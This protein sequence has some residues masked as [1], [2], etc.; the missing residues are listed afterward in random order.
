MSRSFITVFMAFAL[1]GATACSDD[2][3][4]ES[5]ETSEPP[6]SDPAVPGVTSPD[7]LP[8]GTEEDL[9]AAMT[10]SISSPTGTTPFDDATTE[11][12]V[13]AIIDSIG[14]DRLIE[15]GVRPGNVSDAQPLSG[16]SDAEKRAYLDAVAQCTSLRDLV[17][18]SFGLDPP[19]DECV[20]EAIPDEE[21]ARAILLYTLEQNDPTA[22]PTGP[23]GDVFETLQSCQA[24]LVPT[25]TTG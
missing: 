3:G 8:I 13:D 7:D 9:R 20:E 22:V 1:L 15:L 24:E 17:I 2:S 4:S 14:Y 5:S 23:V 16:M 25:D 10:E 11:C 19:F 6:V 21:V 12:L 18:A